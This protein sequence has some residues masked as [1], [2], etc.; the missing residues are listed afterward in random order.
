MA[1]LAAGSAALVGA[2]E[3][4]AQPSKADEA[5]SRYMKGVELHEEGDFQAALIEFR[6]SYELVPNY[7]VLYNIGQEYFQLGDYSNALRTF[8]QYLA[9]GGKRIQPERQTEVNGY[10]DKLRGRIAT[11]NVKINVEGAELRVD[12]QVNSSPIP[13]PVVVSAGKRRFEVSKQ[14][15]RTIKRTE[16]LAGQETKELVFD[17]QPETMITNGDNKQIIVVG[18]GTP[19]PDDGPPIGP[20]VGWSITG[21]LA[22]GAG[23]FGG[24]ALSNQSSLDELK[25]EPGHTEAELDDAASNARAMAIA[26]DVF[27]GAAVIGAG[28]STYFTIDAVISSDKKDTTKGEAKPTA[29][30]SFGPGSVGVSGSF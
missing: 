29:K 1:P 7:H 22:I 17:L 12:D 2:G 9:D 6:R 30:V 8:E 25:R 28:L 14:G 15:Y 5:K 3:A 16:E 23:V 11:V 10:L 13:G 24:I 27:I 19:P 26:T 18:G 4:F 20:I 21:A